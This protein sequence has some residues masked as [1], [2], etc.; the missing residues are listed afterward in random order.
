MKDNRYSYLVNVLS[1]NY[2]EPLISL[3]SNNPFLLFIRNNFNTST[4]QNN[5]KRHLLPETYDQ[6]LIIKLLLNLN[7]LRNWKVLLIKYVTS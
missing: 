4:N 1:D 7:K 6:I 2:K 5:E 3:I